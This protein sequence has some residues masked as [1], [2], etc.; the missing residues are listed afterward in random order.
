M[1]ECPAPAWRRRRTRSP[2]CSTTSP[3][4]TTS[5]TTSSP[6]ARTA[7]GASSSTTP[8]PCGPARASSTS[9]PAPARRAS[10]S[11]TPGS[12]SSPATSRSACSRVGRRRRADLRFV[13]GD[14][15]A[16]AVRGRRVR[17]RHDVVR[18]AQRRRRAG[19]ARRDAPGHAARRPLVVCEFSHPTWRPF[20]TLYTEYLMRALPPLARLVSSNPDAYVYLAESIRAW[21]DQAGLARLMQAAGWRA[22]ST[23]TS[24]AAS[25][26]STGP[27]KRASAP[28]GGD[29]ARVVSVL[30]VRRTLTLV[31]E[32]TSAMRAESRDADV[33]VV[34]AG[35][36]GSSIAHYLAR[37]GVDVLV[38]EKTAFPREKVC[39]DGLT[40][41]AVASSS[42]W[43]S[44][45]APRTAG[46]A[47][48]ASA[49]SAAAFGC[50]SRGR[51]SPRSRTTASSARAS[52]STRCSPTTPAPAAR[53][54]WS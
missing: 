27:P 43:A 53:R 20:R 32:F 50:S 18:P 4:G 28:G 34:G 38:L 2:A 25:S 24:P 40:P 21:P 31:N 54:S 22:S 13:A 42:R 5:R 47:T 11:P 1:P 36:A 6:S 48:R 49:S 8:S 9:R 51:T 30:G 45:R 19:G 10:R 12:A 46:S 14:A 15:T 35:P 3:S 23:A 16:P 33:I 52:T 7:A 39:G 26:P 29:R 17:R 41:R 37:A 44:R